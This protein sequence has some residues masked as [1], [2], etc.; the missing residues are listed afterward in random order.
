MDN[1]KYH[2]AIRLIHWL[3]AFMLL[4]LIISGWYMT[5]L[6]DSVSYKYNIYYWHKSFGVLVLFLL[7][8]RI[9]ARIVYKAPPLPDTLPQYEKKL[10]KVTH[11]CLY[12]LMFL[13]PASGYLMSGAAPNRYVPFFGLTMPN[14]VEKNREIADYLHSVHVVIPYIF[15]GVIIFHLIGTLKHRYFDKHDNDVLKRML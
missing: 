8:S 9:V 6:E 13:V 2:I 1:N 3:M 5:N 4:S 10:A 11:W 15:L 12:I 7:V 14:I